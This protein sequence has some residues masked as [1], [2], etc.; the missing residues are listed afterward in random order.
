[1]RP[2]HALAAAVD[3]FE[4]LYRGAAAR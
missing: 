4:A 3:E 1:V 2:P